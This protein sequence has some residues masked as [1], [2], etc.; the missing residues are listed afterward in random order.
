VYIYIPNYIA[1]FTNRYQIVK[2]FYQIII[3]NFWMAYPGINLTMILYF[4]HCSSFKKNK[5]LS[6]FNFYVT[7]S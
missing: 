2:W 5:K 3:K 4:C 7:F 1:N 6:C